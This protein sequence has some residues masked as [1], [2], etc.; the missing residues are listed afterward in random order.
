MAEFIILWVGFTAITCGVGVLLDL[1][2][3]H[4]Q[5]LK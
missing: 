1:L 2:L 4:L 5:G 3:Q